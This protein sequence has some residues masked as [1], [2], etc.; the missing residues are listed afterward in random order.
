M[1][2]A[3][4]RERNVLL[5]GA[6]K[7]WWGSDAR[8]CT[9][10]ATTDRCTKEEFGLVRWRK[11]DNAQQQWKKQMKTTKHPEMPLKGLGRCT[12]CLFCF[13]CCSPWSPTHWSWQFSPCCT[14]AWKGS[15]RSELNPISS[16]IF[17]S[18]GILLL[19]I[20]WCFF[21]QGHQAPPYVYTGELSDRCKYCCETGWCRETVALSV[22]IH[23]SSLH[24][25]YPG[26]G[27]IANR[28]EQHWKRLCVGTTNYCQSFLRE[29]ASHSQLALF[30]LIVTGKRMGGSLKG[31][32][33]KRRALTFCSG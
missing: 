29:R 10:F 2:S 21:W 8:I 19:D 14:K 7:G 12:C 20:S 25:S 23:S 26:G 30:I 18:A 33:L 27:G 3:C 24:H 16:F 15:P 28:E 1:C 17:L 9:A 6:W 4:N 11:T 32:I 5:A 13:P 31:R 22:A